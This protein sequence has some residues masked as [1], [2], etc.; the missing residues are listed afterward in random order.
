MN[1]AT[2]AMRGILLLVLLLVGVALARHHKNGKDH[3]GDKDHHKDK[4]HHDKDKD[5]HRDRDHHGD[6]DDDDKDDHHDRKASRRQAY[7]DLDSRLNKITA[8]LQHLDDELDKRLDPKLKDRALS[9]EH[10]L[11]ELEERD[12]DKYHYNCGG[13]DQECVSRLFV[14]DGHKDCRNG[15]DEKHC[16]FPTKVGDH[17]HGTVV[18]DHCTQRHP[19]HINFHITAVKESAAYS[20]F[21]MVRAVIEI[22]SEDHDEESSVALPTKGYYRFATQNLILQPPED[23]GLGL[24]C[25]FDGHNFDKCVG[26]IVHM[27]SLEPCAKFIFFRKHDDENGEHD[28]D[29]D[30]HHHHDTAGH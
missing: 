11:E 22:D 6:K 28:D 5:H 21:P 3:H 30:D 19:E 4:D 1:G 2:A 26:N 16:E 13:N 29:D 24:I 14:C 25:D 23:D 10:R 18:F 8:R 27:A 9:L 20:A 12:C 17:F 7:D 15:D